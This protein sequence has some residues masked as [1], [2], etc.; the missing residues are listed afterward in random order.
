MRDAVGLHYARALQ[1]EL[2]AVQAVEETHAVPEQDR[3]DAEAYLVEEVGAEELPCHVGGAHG[4]RSVTGDGPGLLPRG[5][6]VTP[7]PGGGT[8]WHPVTRRV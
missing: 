3:S 4:D 6:R 7:G 1:V 2:P 8:R 5:W